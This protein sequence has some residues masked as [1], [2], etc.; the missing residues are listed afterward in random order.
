[1]LSPEPQYIERVLYANGMTA[2][3]I[4]GV[5]NVLA[6]SYRVDVA[7]FF[8]SPFYLPSYPEQQVRVM[9]WISVRV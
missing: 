1:M 9:V 2:A 3:Q 5:K 4:A 6:S 7:T 8:A